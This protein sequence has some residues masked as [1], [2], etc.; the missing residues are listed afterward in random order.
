MQKLQRLKSKK[1]FSLVELLIVVAIMAVLVGVLAP[2]YIRY[3]ER[4]RQSSDVQSVNGMVNA[5]I[6][7][8]LDPM[9]E[10]E[11][12]LSGSIT[13]T[14]TT[15]TGAIE[16]TS[17]GN[18]STQE[19]AIRSSVRG[20]LNI[21]TDGVVNV[22]SNLVGAATTV[23]MTYLVNADGSGTMTISTTGLPSGRHND[24]DRMFRNIGN[25]THGGT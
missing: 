10:D 20:I 15:V 14:W 21:G 22:R 24:F 17:D 8:T 11:I 16:V 13:V 23:V 3:V 2:Q 19:A 9:L 18:T 1:G 6:T 5:V 25:V 7:T 4:S 12:P